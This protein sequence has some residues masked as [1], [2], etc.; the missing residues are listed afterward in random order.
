MKL[1]ASP[2]LRVE[3]M[4]ARKS[5]LLLAVGIIAT[6]GC[7]A[8][9]IA[10]ENVHLPWQGSYSVRVAVT[11]AT[12]VVA[13]L[14]EVRW[15][16]IVVGRITSVQLQNGQPVLSAEMN[17]ADLRGA[18]LYRDAEVQLRPQTPL[19][20]EYLDVVSRGHRSSG[21]LGPN[22]VLAA[23]QTQTPVNI[24]DVLNTFNEPTRTRLKQL[25][26]ELSTGLTPAGGQQLRSA[27]GE[28]APL[29]VAQ[30]QLSVTIGARKVIVAGLVHDT[31]LLFDELSSR[32]T[33]LARLLQVGAGTFDALGSQ[34][35]A[36]RQLISDLPSTL[37]QMRSSFGQLQTTLADVRP[38]LGA[39]LPTARAM[40]SG[41]NALKRFSLAASPALHTLLPAV[42]ALQPLSKNLSPTA[43]ALHGSFESLKPQAPRLDRIT[44]KV[45]P[46]E[47]AVDKFFAYTLSVLKFGNLANGSA[48]P[49]GIVVT[50]LS[51]FSPTTPDP[52]LTPVIGCA[53]GKP[54]PTS[55]T[56]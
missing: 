47:L 37:T 22:Q 20:D 18:R 6:I 33:E 52:T 15:S 55:T 12:G 32:N 56:S 7:A 3:L 39:L 38:A 4:R 49:R 23:T 1:G 17:P 36:L 19:S 31:R 24:A 50:P 44:A 5:V 43:G 27:F 16:G 25:M 35:P 54:A 2:R 29:L 10:H 11:N 46:C 14:D 8:D 9:L 48:S 45:V 41:L 40:P 53:D 42:S 26:G 28:I 21:L 30:K 34:S 13:G 51:M